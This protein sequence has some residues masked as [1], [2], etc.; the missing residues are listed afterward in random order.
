M[1][2]FEKI[3]V[4][5]NI[6]KLKKKKSNS[7]NESLN[8][9]SSHSLSFIQC[10]DGTLKRIRNKT[11]YKE[12]YLE[13]LNF[14]PNEIPFY[15]ER[16]LS[17]ININNNKNFDLNKTTNSF[18]SNPS[19]KNLKSQ[20]FIDNIVPLSN[21]KKIKK[22]RKNEKLIFENKSLNK[23]IN[24]EDIKNDIFENRIK[25]F[26]KIDNKNI[27]LSKIGNVKNKNDKRE[28]SS[29]KIIDISDYKFE[30]ENDDEEKMN[31][32][33]F[34]KF[35]QLSIELNDQI[36]NSQ[37]IEIDNDKIIIT[38]GKKKFKFEPKKKNK[39]NN[40]LNEKNEETNNENN[41]FT[42]QNSKVTSN[43]DNDD[44]ENKKNNN[45]NNN[46]IKSHNTRY[47]EEE[48]KYLYSLSCSDN[49][50]KYNIS[51]ENSPI[52][53]KQSRQFS[54]VLNDSVFNNEETKENF[55]NNMIIKKETI[56]LENEIDFNIENENNN[57]DNYN[58]ISNGNLK[59]ENKENL[60]S[61][62]LKIYDEQNKKTMNLN[63]EDNENSIKINL[64]IRENSSLSNNDEN[65]GYDEERVRVFDEILKDNSK[66]NILN[67]LNK[68]LENE[69][70]ECKI[71]NFEDILVDKNNKNNGNLN[72]SIN[73]NKKEINNFEISN[74]QK[75]MKDK[76]IKD[77]ISDTN[78]INNPKNKIMDTKNDLFNLNKKNKKNNED[79]L[80]INKKNKKNN[81]KNQDLDI[82]SINN[83]ISE[84]NSNNNS[85][86]ENKFNEKKLKIS[87]QI[88]NSI[89]FN[90]KK[91]N[92]LKINQTNFSIKKS[93]KRNNNNNK[94]IR[95]S[96]EENNNKNISISSTIQKIQKEIDSTK[97][98]NNN[99]E[100]INNNN[101]NTN[102]N[103]IS[104]LT[105]SERNLI[106]DDFIINKNNLKEKKLNSNEIM[107]PNFILK[108]S[109]INNLS[110]ETN[111]I[112]DLIQLLKLKNQSQNVTLSSLIEI[113]ENE[114][115]NKQ[116]NKKNI[117]KM[118]IENKRKIERPYLYGP[119]YINNQNQYNNF[120]RNIIEQKKVINNH[121]SK[122]SFTNSNIIPHHQYHKS[123]KNIFEMN[124]S[125]IN[126]NINYNYF[127]LNKLENLSY[128]PKNKSTKNI[129][130]FYKEKENIQLIFKDIT[131]IPKD[132]Y[133]NKVKEDIKIYEKNKQKKQELNF[134]L[135][136]PV[137]KNIVRAN[138]LG[139]LRKR[140]LG[141]LNIVMPANTLEN[142]ID[143]KAQIF[144]NK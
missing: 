82:I 63:T 109:N 140:S 91:E 107:E 77:K 62:N 99:F 26:K 33:I 5:K 61:N 29:N 88:I 47:N 102:S 92:Y 114:L 108:N 122:S 44:K 70:S 49:K 46:N 81:E 57:L 112:D 37:E 36:Q 124:D 73:K 111:D 141:N 45:D 113:R 94:K 7:E 83:K 11:S 71:N 135:K 121:N 105:P 9:S 10:G 58:V 35:E 90:K 54:V 53:K 42:F 80:Y 28:N 129:Q 43:N 22:K 130:D 20:S 12:I 133:L 6:S 104:P 31:P 38:Q 52:L 95:N 119:N 59:K 40:Y 48:E 75:E 68:D 117:S 97:I 98:N 34:E 4:V 27:F 136:I 144:A 50:N 131:D 125:N 87:P 137:Q 56:N 78:N 96:F 8:T 1:D 143:T 132:K 69:N 2:K 3:K 41:Y 51:K 139:S 89:F 123:H 85:T 106:N 76:K 19:R 128:I 72:N 25:E 60:N 79:L 18:Y 138:T 16:N 103:S 116:K 134:K 126:N 17:F 120:I 100:S 30:N 67:N 14:T 86:N 127:Q 101:N 32:E 66:S 23:K 55:E 74:K 115:K 110:N 21:F 15:K 65:E 13:H 24:N 84:N 118:K 93:Q 39:E 64:N 142:I